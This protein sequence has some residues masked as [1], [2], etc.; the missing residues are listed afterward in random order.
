Y[1]KTATYT[2]EASLQLGAALAGAPDEGLKVLTDY[3]I[4]AGIAFQIQDDILGMFGDEEKLGKPADSDL[5]EGKMNFL[6]IKTLENSNE[7][8]AKR[9]AEILGNTDIG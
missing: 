9:F 3:S 8:D 1:L 5:K 4:P 2:Y 6:T 7:I